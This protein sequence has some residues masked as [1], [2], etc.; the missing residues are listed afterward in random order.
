M[1]K[2]SLFLIAAALLFLC[3]CSEKTAE[4][5]VYAYVNSQEITQKEFDFFL[6][7]SRADIMR[8]FSQ[9]YN[10]SDFSDFWSTEYGGITPQQA[11][12]KRALENAAQAKVK[13]IEMQKYGIYDGVSWEYF[14]NKAAEYNK[15]R[16]TEKGVGLSSVDMTRFYTYYLSLGEIELRKLVEKDG[17]TDYDE[18][19]EI[20]TQNMKISFSPPDKTA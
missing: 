10:I 8:E 14:E 17:K 3:S 16:S 2:I 11:L 9:E 18:Y 6:S 19:I 12:E 20:L 7:R 13:F 1:K 4:N 5:S 15:S